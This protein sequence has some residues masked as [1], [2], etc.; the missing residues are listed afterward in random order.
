MT[1]N[2]RVSA[3]R[4]IAPEQRDRCDE[5]HQGNDCQGDRDTNKNKKA[6]SVI[7]CLSERLQAVARHA[8]AGRTLGSAKRSAR[9]LAKAAAPNQKR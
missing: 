4:P 7:S 2:L 1:F 3:A 5:R 6:H 8:A 9:W